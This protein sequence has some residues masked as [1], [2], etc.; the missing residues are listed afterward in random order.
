[1]IEPVA[2]ITMTL[3]IP[4]NARTSTK[5][6]IPEPLYTDIISSSKKTVWRVKE[7]T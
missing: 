6:T 5:R 1:M 4:K 3:L 7:K 2:S